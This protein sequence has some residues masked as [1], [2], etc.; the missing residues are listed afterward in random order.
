MKQLL[1][2]EYIRDIEY[3][4]VLVGKILKSKVN[5]ILDYLKNSADLLNVNLD[6]LKRVHKH[7]QDEA[8]LHILLCLE[9]V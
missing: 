6:H 9:E 8:A 1:P 4:K 2:N 7:P 3:Q 5:G